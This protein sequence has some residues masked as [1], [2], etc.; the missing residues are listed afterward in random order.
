MKKRM[1]AIVLALGLLT[2]SGCRSA[3]APGASSSGETSAVETVEYEEVTLYVPNSTADGLDE[4]TVQVEKTDLPIEELVQALVG[5]GALPAGT[6]VREWLSDEADP[7][8]FKL[9][10]NETFA[11]GILNQGT[12]G[13]TLM[14]ASLVNTVWAYFTPAELT[15]TADG[16]P[17]ETGHNIYDTPFTSPMALG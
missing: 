2:V 5:E 13:E 4:K 7:P 15:V 12:A 3:A 11:E 9:D 10:L 1:M 6:E 17:I 8:A 16:K 14:L